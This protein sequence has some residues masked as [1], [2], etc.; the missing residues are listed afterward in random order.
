MRPLPFLT[1]YLSLP[2]V[3][4]AQQARY[5]L[6]T[7]DTL[8]YHEVTETKTGIQTPDGPFVIASRHDAAIAL[9]RGS[10][11][12]VTAWYERLTLSSTSPRGESRPA[13]DSVLERPFRLI[14]PA[15]GR[16]RTL[17]TPEF[18]AEVA[19]QTDLSHQFDDFFIS[20]PPGALGPASSWADTSEDSVTADPRDTYRSRRIRTYRVL[21]DTVVMGM[22][23]LVI[24]LEE[25]MSIRSTSPLQSRPGTVGVTIDGREDGFVVF[26]PS[27]GR[28][29]ARQRT[30]HLAG[31]TSLDGPDGRM[32]RAMTYDYT[33]SIEVGR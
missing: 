7:A 26:S 28:L 1:L 3:L 8:R 11:D 18:P 27:A 30:G 29:L 19:R 21:G 31:E 33:S 16:V 9:L 17:T 32:A 20:L 5:L 25:L 14:L 13:T 10:G 2:G 22:N 12:T 15:S 4:V 23:G 24:G 6:G